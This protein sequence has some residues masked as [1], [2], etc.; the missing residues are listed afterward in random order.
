MWVCVQIALKM[1][2]LV[3]LTNLDLSIIF[4]VSRYDLR[5]TR[6]LPRY[7]AIRAANLLYAGMLI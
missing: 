2:H 7:L 1:V 5:H 6:L 3:C 4:P